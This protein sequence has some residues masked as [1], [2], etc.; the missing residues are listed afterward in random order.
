MEIKQQK[1]KKSMSTDDYKCLCVQKHG[2]AYNLDD[3]EYTSMK[4]YVFP[5][6][7]KHGKFKIRAFD[8]AYLR[9]CPHCGRDNKVKTPFKRKRM[10]MTFDE[11]KTTAEQ[12]H[13][14]KYEYDE[15]S[16]VNLKTKMNIICPIHGVFQQSPHSHLNGHGCNQ[17]GV[18]KR[19]LA[20]TT[21]TEEFVEKC[22]KIHNG[23]YIYSQTNYTDCY[24]DVDIICPKHGLFSM[25]AYSHLQ[26][27]GC[28]QCAIEENALKMLKE[29]EEF[30]KEAKIK[31]PNENNDY[32]LVKYVGAK[33]P[34]EIVCPNGHHYFQ[35]PNKH[36]IGHGCP[37]CACYRSR[38]ER[39]IEEFI[40]ELGLEYETSNRTLLNGDEI[41]ILI[42]SKK[43][44][45]EYNGLYWHSDLFKSSDY[46]LKKSLQC[47]KLGYKLIH[48]FEDEW[49]THKDICVS[50]LKRLCGL[51][52]DLINISPN[53]CTIQ[54]NGHR[55]DI[56]GF[57]GN[58]TLEGRKP[59][60]EAIN[61]YFGDVLIATMTF[62][63]I[64]SNA[65]ELIQIAYHNDYYCKGIEEVLFQHFIKEFSPQELI[66]SVD[67]S[68]NNGE[69][70]EK[71]GFEKYN[72]TE[73]NYFY[74]IG[75]KRVKNI[76]P[77]GTSKIYDCGNIYYKKKFRDE[78]CS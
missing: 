3:V 31:H 2:D 17:C 75:N 53:D 41:D 7:K 12:I 35:M 13:G 58:Y 77:S 65:W 61:A 14:H 48:I 26:G 64:G 8:F 46:H 69:L 24:N 55:D 47:E 43:I 44:A 29:Q 25:A 1:K 20:Q 62:S 73:P 18:I 76:Q 11:F 19:S 37:K 45:I 4:D 57:L 68:W 5:S 30:I 28:K 15:S 52:D 59:F 70:L 22:N 40:K 32:S 63:N 27:H 34:V 74:V 60:T 9:G 36:L 56:S 50:K 39:E 51:T 71:N 66:A 21:T 38:G 6:C 10:N 78:N 23:K 72:E 54:I 16:F 67:R 33:I 42:P 49:K